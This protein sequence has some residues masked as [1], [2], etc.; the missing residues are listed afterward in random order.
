MWGPKKHD[1]IKLTV[2]SGRAHST[3]SRDSTFASLNPHFS[4]HIPTPCIPIPYSMY[5]RSSLPTNCNH[6]EMVTQDWQEGFIQDKSTTLKPASIQL[7]TTQIHMYSELTCLTN[8]D[9][10]KIQ[11]SAGSRWGTRWKEISA[12]CPLPVEANR[13][14]S[15][16]STRGGQQPR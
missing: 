12:Q 9:D 7:D 1:R 5:Q 6:L 10:G 8:E 13:N 14:K 3:V 4:L 15:S 16:Q 2:L 11:G